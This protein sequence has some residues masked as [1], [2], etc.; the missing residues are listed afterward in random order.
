MSLLI[1]ADC[2]RN[3]Q[4]ALAARDWARVHDLAEELAHQARLRYL[5]ERANPQSE[6][7]N[8]ESSVP[9]THAEPSVELAGNPIGA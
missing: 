1:L 7:R 6:I 9:P 3:L 5:D 4:V 2:S 8:P